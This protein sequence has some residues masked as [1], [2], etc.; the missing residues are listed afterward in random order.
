MKIKLL[1]VYITIF[2]L[3]GC[4]GDDPDSGLSATVKTYLNDMVDIMMENSINRNTID[5]TTFRASVIE[6]A[7]TSQT[8]AETTEAI[9]HALELL[10]DGTTFLVTSS[11]VTIKSSEGCTDDAAPEVVSDPEIGYI[12]VPTYSNTG[13]T[14]AIFAQ[15]MQGKIQTANKPE[16]KGWVIDVRGNTG[17]NMWAMLAGIGPLLGEETAGYFVD[18]DGLK[19]A[20]LYTNGSVKYGDESIITISFPYTYT[21][22]KT[23]RIAVIMDNATASSG[24]AVV[25][26]FSGKSNVKTFGVATCGKSAGSQPFLLLDGSLL[27]LTTALIADRSEKIY[28]EPIVPD[29]VVVDHSLIY[30]AAA[31]WIKE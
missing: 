7:G 15:S 31:G 8:I 9:K 23:A 14:A 28:N 26:A 20:F 21:G 2:G 11:G 19:T 10:D 29:E 25:I 17:G 5:W 30:S 27:Y 4:G 1:I 24:E 3:L 16:L 13:L 6:K 22:S 12:Q 18:A